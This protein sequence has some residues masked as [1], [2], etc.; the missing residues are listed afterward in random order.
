MQMY[1]NWGELKVLQYFDYMRHNL[2]VSDTYTV[3]K[4]MKV[5]K[6]TGLSD[7]EFA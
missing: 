7:A 5:T 1:Y 3:V 4:V 2:V 6:H